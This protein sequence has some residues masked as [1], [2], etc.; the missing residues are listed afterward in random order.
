MTGML[1]YLGRAVPK[2]SMSLIGMRG[3]KRYEN[4]SYECETAVRFYLTDEFDSG[5]FCS[6]LDGV[7]KLFGAECKMEEDSGW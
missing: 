2:G 7:K 1:D 6:L 4:E 3:G 5:T